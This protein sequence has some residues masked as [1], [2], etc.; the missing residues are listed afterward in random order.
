ML[1]Y[2]LRRLAYVAPIA[3]G[4]TLIVFLLVHIAPGDPIS[5]IL[6]DDASAEMVA[7]ARREYGLDKPLPVQYGIWLWRAAQGELGTSI[8]SGRTVASELSMAVGNTFILA[9]AAGLL[10][11]VLGVALGLVAG[12]ARDRIGDHLTSLFTLAGVS[13]PHYWVAIL[14]V[15][16][17]AVE[18]PWLPPLG[19][20][21][22]SS[23]GWRPDWAHLQHLILPAIATALIPMAVIARTMRASVIEALD[24]DFVT[25]LHAKGLLPGR[26]LWHVLRNALPTTLAVTGLQLGNMLGGSVLV[27][28][29]F[30]WPGTGFLLANAIF[31]RD[32]PVLQGTMLVLSLFFVV[33]NLAVDLLQSWAD[34]RIRRA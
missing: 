25:T 15:I 4:V 3:V 27:E 33:L 24:Q 7:E 19:M 10:A 32:L 34:P 16:V 12:L 9:V 21:P 5:A 14:L 6:P 8:R 23:D 26:R 17:F 18:N 29:V 13:L 11:C 20:G 1:R 30:A 31:Q 22:D 2:L 28:T